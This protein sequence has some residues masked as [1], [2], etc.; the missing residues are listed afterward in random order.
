[1]PVP[2]DS[3]SPFRQQRWIECTNVGEST[4]SAFSVVEVTGSTRPEATEGKTPGGGRTVL[5]VDV[6]STDSPE[7]TVVLGPY[8]IPAGGYGICTADE[9]MYARYYDWSPANGDQAGVAEGTSYLSPSPQYGYIILGD[10]ADG[11]VRVMR[12]HCPPA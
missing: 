2:Q 3:R 10:A 12:R 5:E 6:A 8:D 4:L 9:P 7:A 1:M 11:L